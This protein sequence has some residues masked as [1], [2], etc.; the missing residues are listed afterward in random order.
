MNYRHSYHAGN[1]ADV[2]KHIIL[3]ALTESLLRKDNGFCFLDTHAGIGV[4]D[5]QA[6]DAKKTQESATGILKILQQPN[7]PALIQKYLQ[8]INQLNPDGTDPLRFYPGSPEFVK[9]F[10]R[11][12]DRMVLTELHEEDYET[13]K[14]LY[15]REKQ[16]AVH[17]Q[18][19]YNALKAFLP[20]KERR[21]LV[22]IDPPYEK[23]DELMQ[24][25]SVLC[26]A[27]ERWETGVYALWYPIKEHRSIER[28]HQ[29]VKQ[30]IARPAL[31]VEL[32]IYPENIATHLNGSGMLIIN[33][34]WQLDTA[35]KSTLAWLW[36]TLSPNKQ[37]RYDIKTL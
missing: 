26:N 33:P 4:Y 20:P 13:L 1:F 19:G 28:F 22:L 18:D 27:L 16:I 25:I 7:P 8:V 9:Y 37:G 36:E 2:F 35:I 23:P 24:N 31:T 14:Q 29:S 3:T 11:P 10:L 30:R 17:H 21:G 12:Q 15:W 32:S 6:P 34:P 5:L